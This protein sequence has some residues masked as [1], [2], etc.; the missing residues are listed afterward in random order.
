M[1]PSPDLTTPWEAARAQGVWACPRTVCQGPRAQNDHIFRVIKRETRKLD[2]VQNHRIQNKRNLRLCLF[3]AALLRYAFQILA[4][5][6]SFEGWACTPPPAPCAPTMTIR[7]CWAWVQFA[8][9]SSVRDPLR[10]EI[11]VVPGDRVSRGCGEGCSESFVFLSVRFWV[12]SVV[13]GAV[14]SPAPGRAAA[15]RPPQP[16]GLVSAV[17]GNA[18]PA[19]PRLLGAAPHPAHASSEHRFVISTASRKLHRQPRASASWPLKLRPCVNAPTA[20]TSG[21]KGRWEPR[22]PLEA[23]A[24]CLPHTHRSFCLRS[25]WGHRVDW[26]FI[27]LLPAGPCWTAFSSGLLQT[28]R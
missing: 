5:I 3:K 20:V 18:W 15:P 21:A 17:A 8:E 1:R 27:S 10:W 11:R 13:G 19:R 2:F 7:G 14:S 22:S 23:R 16:P 4:D 28:M 25:C 9:G 12:R 6:S 26:H 24:S